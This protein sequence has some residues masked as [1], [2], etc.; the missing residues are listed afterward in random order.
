MS[1]FL[2]VRVLSSVLVLALFLGSRLLPATESSEPRITGK[3]ETVDGARVLSLW[4]SHHDRG[5]AHGW[6]LA[7]E[8]FGVAEEGF[9]FI[10]GRAGPD[11]MAKIVPMV[12][13]GFTFTPDEIS[14]MEGMVDAIG[15]RFPDRKVEAMGGQPFDLMDIKLINTYGDWA[16][17]GCSA[18]AAWG[19][20]SADGKPVAARNWDFLAFDFLLKWTHVRAVGPSGQR[21][22]WVGVSAP[23][24]LGPVTAMNAEGVFIAIDD[25][26][27]RPEAKDFIQGNVPRLIALR[28]IMEEVPAERAVEKAV[29]L[30]RSWNTLFGNN[31]LVVTPGS[32]GLPAGVLEYD[33]REKLERGVT[34]RAP[35]SEGGAPLEYIA[36]SNGHRKRGK[37]SCWRYDA[38]VK[39]CGERKDAFD[40]PALVDLV[41][42]SAVPAEG[43]PVQSLEVGTL[44]QV[45][46]F[47]GERKLWMRFIEGAGKSIRD[48]KG[49]EFRV[50]ALLSGFPAGGAGEW[51]L[52][53]QD[54]FDRE[55]QPDPAN[56]DH[57]RGFVRNDELQWYQPENATCKGGLLVIEARRERKPNPG[58][59]P[60][61][62][63]FAGREAIEVTSACLITKGKHEF[64]YVKFEMRA[65][66][67]TRLGS[68]PAFWT[69]GTGRARWPECGEIDIMEYYTGTV[70][71]NV[72]HAIGGT[73]K[74]LTTKKP[75]SELGGETWAKE[76]H[77]WT[78]EW[79]EKRIALLLDGKLSARFDVSQDDE[80]GKENAF[81][82]PHSILLNQAIGGRSGGDHSKLEY[83]VRL[84]VDWVRVYER[85][86]GGG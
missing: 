75:L 73:Q 34:L 61:A 31:F 40:L 2:P 53:W 36:C 23:G 78:M 47:T 65:R 59:R 3:L 16:P 79:D 18:A 45:I 26:W 42:R 52:V 38:L 35:D 25:V 66:I 83:P 8:I 22:G 13:I 9:T 7:E 15:K 68:W 84:E 41:S 32:G 77:V 6:L 27:V 37:D 64:R 72:C 17:L 82:K 14:E 63:G 49:I 60:E 1:N 33:T 5:F 44:H 80:A 81:R 28:R 30:C 10:K 70:L 46:A 11:V 24:L 4:G 21:R 48:A 29:D 12:T 43:K 57:E 39:G 86:P 69:L 19:K 20:L 67:D 54:E 62:K 56:W 71:A 85:V 51:K 55:G 76:F 58:Y 74:W 50:D